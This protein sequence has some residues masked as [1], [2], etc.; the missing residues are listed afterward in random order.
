MSKSPAQ[1]RIANGSEILHD[2]DG[3]RYN[4]RR[5][6]EVREKLLRTLPQPP[7]PIQQYV[8]QSAASLQVHLEGLHAAQ[9]RG[10]RVDTNVL[11]KATGVMRRLLRDLAGAADDRDE[12]DD[13]LDAYLEGRS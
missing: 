7:S 2:V 10:E 3:R 11:V 1:S 6:R 8:A 9:A 13:P 4:A 12:G 5:Y